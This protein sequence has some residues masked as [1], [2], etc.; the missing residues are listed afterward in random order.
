MAE[1][2]KRGLRAQLQ[3][4]NLLTGELFVDLTFVANAPPA[5]LDTSGPIPVIPSVPATI[6]ALQASVTAIM[7]KI[8]ALPLE[9]LVGSLTKTATGLEAIVNSP[10]IKE[11]A[12]SLGETMA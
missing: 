9:Q 1:L 10:E 6:E 5:E 2:V 12:T 7:N 8:A 11:A 4:G 3:T